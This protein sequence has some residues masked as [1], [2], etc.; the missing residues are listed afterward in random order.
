MESTNLE[1]K[2]EAFRSLAPSR[3]AAA[4]KL[5]LSRLPLSSAT[6]ASKFSLIWS[7]STVNPLEKI[8]G[9]VISPMVTSEWWYTPIQPPLDTQEPTLQKSP[10]GNLNPRQTPTPILEVDK[11]VEI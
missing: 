5:A 7:G 8:L 4:L 11:Q 9:I 1:L 6:I 3:F 10:L 2:M